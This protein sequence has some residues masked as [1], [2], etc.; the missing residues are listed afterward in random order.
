MVQSLEGNK[1]LKLNVFQKLLKVTHLNRPN[2]KN[3]GTKKHSKKLK[4]YRGKTSH[5]VWNSLKRV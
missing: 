4:H 2:T 5:T 1:K 3:T